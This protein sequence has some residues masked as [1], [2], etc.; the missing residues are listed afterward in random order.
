M[1]R[2]IIKDMED[3]EGDAQFGCMTLPVLW[4]LRKTKVVLYILLVTFLISFVYLSF[5]NFNS[6]WLPFSLTM[7]VLSTLL[8][9]Q[10]YAADTRKDFSW[11]S[12]Y[13]KLI[14]ILGLGSM[15]FV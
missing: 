15:Y 1:V 11:L 6:I 8:M 5:L 9:Q 7:M 14:M 2:E 12:N 10:V 13:C 3:Q 4:G